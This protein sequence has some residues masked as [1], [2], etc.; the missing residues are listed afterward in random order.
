[1]LMASN[2]KEVEI[3]LYF[4]FEYRKSCTI[5]GDTMLELTCA[6]KCSILHLHPQ[7]LS[8]DSQHFTLTLAVLPCPAVPVTPLVL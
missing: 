8:Q 2:S 5:K 6:T 1:M 3:L 4:E 7:L